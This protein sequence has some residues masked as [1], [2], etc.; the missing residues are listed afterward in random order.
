MGEESA[1]GGG[2]GRVAGGGDPPVVFVPD[3]PRLRLALRIVVQHALKDLDALVGRTVVDEDDV[4]IPVRLL[5][6]GA[7]APLDVFL[8]A[9]DGHEDTNLVGFF[10]NCYLLDRKTIH[11]A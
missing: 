8:Y 10:H 7:G 3:D 11:V 4:E 6:D 2:H 1:G 9:I 5:K